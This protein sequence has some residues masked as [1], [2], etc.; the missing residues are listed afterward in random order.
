MSLI[1]DSVYKASSRRIQY[2]SDLQDTVDHLGLENEEE[3]HELCEALEKSLQELDASKVP[4]AKK[5]YST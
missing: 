3:D 4:V 1:V 5:C 2:P